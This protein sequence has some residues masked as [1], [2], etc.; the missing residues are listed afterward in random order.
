[1]PETDS[2]ALLSEAA[3]ALDTLRAKRPLVECLANSVSSPLMADGLLAVG[4]S[5]AMVAD[6]DEAAALAAVGNALIVNVGTLNLAEA[7][8]MRSAVASANSHAC[9]W[10]LD[11]VGVGVLPLRTEFSREI[12]QCSPA[13]IRGNA[14]EIMVLAGVSGSEAG[15]RGVD[16]TARGEDALAAAVRLANLTHAAV[17]VSGETD[18]VCHEGADVLAVKN[19]SA[20]MTR[21]AG[22]GCLQG[23][24]AAA[25]LGALGRERRRLAALAAALVSGIAGEKAAARASTPGSFRTAFLDELFLLDRSSFISSAIFDF[26]S[27]ISDFKLSFEISNRK[28]ES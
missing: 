21:I 6:P 24:I 1:M 19:G 20:V 10:A 13:I 16:S 22:T 27:Q 5:P 15:G 2:V 9:P 11:P 25:F 12:M 26:K 28:S 8:T 3:A 18:Y 7:A 14:S 4:A 17:L 23:A